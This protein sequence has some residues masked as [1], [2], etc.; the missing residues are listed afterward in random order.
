MHDKQQL[1]KNLPA[2]D[3]VLDC[4]ELSSSTAPH[5]LVVDAAREAVAYARNKI[6]AAQTDFSVELESIRSDAGARLK[7]KLIPSLREVI[8]ATGTLLHTNL[9]RAP[10]Y[11]A[12]LEDMVSIA[13]GYS[14][15]ELDLESGKRGHRYSHVD[16]LLCRLTGAEAAAVVNNNAG[17]VLLALTALARGREAVVSRGELVEI[18]GAFRVPDVMEAGGV[19][20]REVGTTNKTHV[21]DYR[22]AITSETGLLL[23]VHTSNYRIVGFTQSV[24]ANE[25]VNLGREHDIPVMEDLG[26]GMLFDL[27][28]FGL[29]REPTVAEQ[30]EAGIDVITFSGDK[31][32][33][34][35]QAG[36][37]VGK[38]WAIDAI[39]RH[40]LA[41]AL[42]MDK[43]TIA[44][45]ET[46]LRQYLD[47]EQ[48]IERIPVLQMLNMSAET[49]HERSSTFAQQLGKELNTAAISEYYVEIVA[50]NS[51]VGGG[52]L[53]ITDLPG[54]AVALRLPNLSLDRLALQLR[55]QQPAIVARIQDDALI[56]NLRTVF[57]TQF[58]ALAQ[59]ITAGVLTLNQDKNKGA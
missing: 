12:A 39:R 35:P 29:P 58:K 43:L 19:E 42:R 25:L 49:L 6:L 22:N 54:S 30:V 46:T 51:C 21:R 9:G 59:G 48:A 1:L 33:G 57:P 47:R 2:V 41:R 16:E 40:P 44:A 56:L 24:D 17:A 26:S 53:P 52:A 13:R 15:L 10:L 3:K 50:Q 55:C 18:G 23:K 20:L 31:L 45:L 11:T 7:R 32:L 5:S 37:I 38:K 36:I 34:G 8:N 27:S 14:N 4:V 28:A